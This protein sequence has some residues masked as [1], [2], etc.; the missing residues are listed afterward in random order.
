M[1]KSY[2][3]IDDK[4]FYLNTETNCTKVTD[5][6]SKNIE[7]IWKIP[8]ITIDEFAKLRVF[9]CQHTATT[10]TDHVGKILSF[11]L[12][13]VLFNP[14]T[15]YSSD[16]TQYPLIFSGTFTSEATYWNSDFSGITIIPQTINAI[17]IVVSDS[18]T[19]QTSGISTNLSFV[20]GMNIQQYDLKL[21]EINN[22][23]R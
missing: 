4:I 17:S 10:D 3:V 22:P 12:K 23:Y 13:N 7:F 14:S 5:G 1:N 19:S 8:S 9:T 11:R 16:N 2:K 6:G 20:I 18:L 21:S 15:Y